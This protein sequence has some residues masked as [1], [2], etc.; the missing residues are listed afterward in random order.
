MSRISAKL[1]FW[2]PRLLSIAFIAF[3]SLFSLDVF[4]GRLG[5]WRTMLA[6]TM[7][8]IPV[9]V[10]TAALIAAWK[11]EWIGAVLYA[12]AGLHYVV[13]VV[14]MSRPVPPEIR[15]SWILAIAGP[16]FVIAGLFLV[17]WL[18]HDQIR[19]TGCQGVYRTTSTGILTL[20]R[21][22]STVSP[23]RRSPTKR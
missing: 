9:F 6:L 21:T 2:A 22:G 1:L 11:W 13:W 14:A 19:A 7:H 16:A 23:H 5:F 8:L 3:L 17:N 10:L 18:K 15:R 12:A 4:D 20:C